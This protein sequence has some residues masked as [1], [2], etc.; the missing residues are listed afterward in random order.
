M[1]YKFLQMQNILQNKYFMDNLLDSVKSAKIS[2]AKKF[3]ECFPCFTSVLQVFNFSELIW[4]QLFQYF[5]LSSEM[6][7]KI[8]SIHL[9]T[10][11][12]KLDQNVDGKAYGQECLPPNLLSDFDFDD[13][14]PSY[15]NTYLYIYVH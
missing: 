15:F 8:A 6:K 2:S 5:F 7:K 14:D 9:H 11:A 10:V 12:E 13:L 4:I 3:R 1:Q